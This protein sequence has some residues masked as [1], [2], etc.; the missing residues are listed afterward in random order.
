M[1]NAVNLYRFIKGRMVQVYLGATTLRVALAAGM[2]AV[3]YPATSSA[4]TLGDSASQMTG[5]FSQFA[6]LL[7][8]GAALV[9]LCMVIYGITSLTYLHRKDPREHSVK[10]AVLLLAGG[11]VLCGIVWF[12]G[13]L[14]TSLFGSTHNSGLSS[15]GVGY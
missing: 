1:R 13:N 6:G 14:S 7:K 12:A 15:L 4:Q 9:G 10:N 5:Q 11:G 8:A 2:V 3:M